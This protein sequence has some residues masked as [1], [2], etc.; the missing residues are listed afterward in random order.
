MIY[1]FLILCVQGIYMN[2]ILQ[3]QNT[4]SRWG[5]SSE[6]RAKILLP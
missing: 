5:K 4:F 6:L 3:P 1:F 2:D